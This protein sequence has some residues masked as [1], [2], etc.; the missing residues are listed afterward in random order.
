[1]N[2]AKHDVL[3]IG[4]GGSLGQFV[5]VATKIGEANDLI[6]LVVVPQ[7]HSRGTQG[8]FGRSNARIH[9]AVRKYKI[10]IE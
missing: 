3:S 10:I 2:A 1:M 6:A 4:F 9:R 8:S 7:N 5:G